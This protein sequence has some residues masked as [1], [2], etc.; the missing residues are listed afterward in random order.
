[1][2]KT[3]KRK[4]IALIV[5]VVALFSM[6][7][8]TYT[9][10]SDN[11]FYG[12][13]GVA[14]FTNFNL[15]LEEGTNAASYSGLWDVS[16]DRAPQHNTTTRVSGLPGHEIP[17]NS[18]YLT[19]GD[20]FEFMVPMSIAMTGENMVASISM[21]FGAL[22]ALA[23]D[24]E[25]ST[26]LYHLDWFSPTWDAIGSDT[27]ITSANINDD[28]IVGYMQPRPLSGSIDPI[29][30]GVPTTDRRIINSWF[31]TSVNVVAVVTLSMPL[32]ASNPS[33]ML[34]DTVFDQITVNLKQTRESG[35]GNFL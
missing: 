32:S 6:I 11:L 27:A 20:T 30:A 1:M 25:I 18:W 19:P 9:L 21:D 26:H 10:W 24:V 31:G 35:V 17:T 23:D 5:G 22:A 4:T 28:V 15:E 12:G 8:G 34:D 29:D 2:T 14:T 3:A 16:P 13:D 7:G 33:A